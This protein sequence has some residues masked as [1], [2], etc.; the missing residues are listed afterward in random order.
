MCS[1][2]FE[3]YHKPKKHEEKNGM[4]F[5]PYII[6]QVHAE[7]SQMHKKLLIYIYH[8][9]LK[10]NLPKSVWSK[11]QSDTHGIMMNTGAPTSTHWQSYL[12]Q[13][14]LT[15]SIVYVYEEIEEMRITYRVRLIGL[16]WIIVVHELIQATWLCGGGDVERS[17]KQLQF[18]L[19]V[20]DP[21]QERIVN[22][23]SCTLSH[24]SCLDFW[25]VMLKIVFK[26]RN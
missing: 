8:C 1:L 22:L 19:C 16:A 6:T 3:D 24:K 23:C 7:R 15:T 2:V 5:Q 9:W 14:L 12:C 20:D 25:Q 18:H 17:H 21:F 10:F 4:M 13:T 26:F 11:S